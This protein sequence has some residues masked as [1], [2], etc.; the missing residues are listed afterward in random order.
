MNIKDRKTQR[1]VR[2]RKKTV[3]VTNRPRLSVF[4]SNNY[5]Y[6]QIIDV[7]GNI[8]ASVSEKT[9]NLDA[10][11]APVERAKQVGAEIA[12]LALAKKIK[13]VAFDKGRFAYHGRVK[14]VAEGAREG[15]L[16]L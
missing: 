8:V 10:K 1:Q 4:R 14:A 16:N 3:N 15:G 11:V 2:V 9:V 6:V 13:D 7:T 12:K 5:V